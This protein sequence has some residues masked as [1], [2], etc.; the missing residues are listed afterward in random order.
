MGHIT[1][2]LNRV[3]TASSPCTYWPSFVLLE[4][5][6]GSGICDWLLVVFTHL[7]LFFF[8]FVSITDGRH[9]FKGGANIF[10]A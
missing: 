10:D 3:H 8:F 7:L 2:S 9:R 5:I 6:F 1:S 4:S